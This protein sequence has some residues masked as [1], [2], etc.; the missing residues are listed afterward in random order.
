MQFRVCNVLESC[1]S[2]NILH[3]LKK[4]SQF[5]RQINSLDLTN[6]FFFGLIYWNRYKTLVSA[7]KIACLFKGGQSVP[8]RTLDAL[9][10]F[11][12][13][14]YEYFKNNC[15]SYILIAVNSSNWEHV[16]GLCSY[17]HVFFVAVKK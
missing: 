4:T 13:I 5:V 7:D 8:D 10:C 16:H 3:D 9:N 12:F 6:R 17:M 11:F 15:E 1:H 14:L 2:T